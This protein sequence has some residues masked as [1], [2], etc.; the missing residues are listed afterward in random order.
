MGNRPSRPPAERDLSWGL[1]D[2][3]WALVE[4]CWHQ[5]P[6]ERPAARAIVEF[7]RSHSNQDSSERPEPDWDKTFMREIRSNL[8]GH[9]FHFISQ[10]FAAADTPHSPNDQFDSFT[11]TP[12]SDEDINDYLA[13]AYSYSNETGI[14]LDMP[15]QPSYSDGAM[16]TSSSEEASPGFLSPPSEN[17]PTSRQ[18]Y[19]LQHKGNFG[20]GAASAAS[21]GR[22]RGHQR[23]K[24]EPL[25]GQYD[26]IAGDIWTMPTFDGSDGDRSTSDFEPPPPDVATTNTAKQ[27][28][29]TPRETT[30]AKHV[31][32]EC[33]D[34]FTTDNDRKRM[35]YGIQLLDRRSDR[36]IHRS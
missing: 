30:E 23:V 2:A 34:S 29:A 31:C 27:P 35:S 14:L 4:A 13:D 9:P 36:D 33:G 26:I 1:D 16:P 22:H 3:L 10:E 19:S 28:I 5:R 18:R 12:I 15:P 6:S 20:L 24:S 25:W 21:F 8:E 32:S 11:V 17:K 7:I